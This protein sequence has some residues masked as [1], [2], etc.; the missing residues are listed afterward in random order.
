MS[1]FI[2]VIKENINLL[3]DSDTGYYHTFKI[4]DILEQ[5]IYDLKLNER[6][7]LLRGDYTKE[8]VQYTIRHAKFY[9]GVPV[10]ARVNMW[11][12]IELGYVLDITKLVLR[13]KK[14]EELGI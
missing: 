10:S 1:I 13:N 7:I 2:E 12:L 14:I 4:G 3:I 11:K 9:G 8:I 5:D 6:T